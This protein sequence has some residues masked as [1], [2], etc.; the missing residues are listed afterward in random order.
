MIS[1]TFRVSA[2][3][4]SA[5]AVIAIG[6]GL[7]PGSVQAAMQTGSE[8]IVGAMPAPPNKPGP[9]VVF[10]WD[11]K[12]GKMG[13]ANFG[14]AATLSGNSFR[15]ALSPDDN[16]IYVPTPAGMT[17]I[18]NPKT[19]AQTGEFKTLT[20]GRVAALAPGE[21]LLIVLSDKGL[22]GYKT[23]TNKEV[24]NLD[25]GG[26]AI[27]FTPDGTRAFV[28]G[29]MSDK[30]TEVDLATGAV[31]Q[32]FDIARSAD[33]AFVDGRLFSA[34]MQ[35]GVMSVLNPELGKITQIKT[36]EVDPKF[37][38]MDMANATAGFM[39]MA[40]DP[41]AHR[42]YVT[43]FS[44]NILS[45]DTQKPAYLGQVAVNAVMGKPNKLSGIALINQGKEALVTVENQDMTV[46]VQLSDGKVIKQM[47]GIESN[48]WISLEPAMG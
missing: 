37:N 35:T 10:S 44:G 38:Y 18:V 28:G 12:T 26:N 33:L 7:A 11:K 22:A 5:A 13:R 32:T 47:P 6:V 36:P 40:V 15:V 20:G 45:F 8:R 41:G 43:G 25:V 2:Q 4:A 39:E 1:R 30:V 34:D 27:A 29:N 23:T 9:G 19:M 16:R 31:L 48:R 42:L 24:Y 46:L 14:K 17:Y 21:K 3:L